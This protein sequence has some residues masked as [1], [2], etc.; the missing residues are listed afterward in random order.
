MRDLYLFLPRRSLELTLRILRLIVGANIC[1]DLVNRIMMTQTFAVV[2]D[3][4]ERTSI[5]T[6]FCNVVLCIGCDFIRTES[7]PPSP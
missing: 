7:F 1:V 3:A 6:L 5:I 4:D 2:P